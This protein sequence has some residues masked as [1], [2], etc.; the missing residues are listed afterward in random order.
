MKKFEDGKTYRLIN[1]ADS[2][3]RALNVLS[4]SKPAALTNVCLYKYDA[5]DTCQQWIY[6]ETSK[7]KYFVCKANTALALDQ[8]TGSSSTANVKNYNAHVYA[9][10]ATSYIIPKYSYD[11][12]GEVSY[13]QI[14]L[15]NDTTKYLTANENAS[16]TAAGK[17]VNAAGNV[18]WYKQEGVTPKSQDW[19]VEVV[20]EEENPNPS[21][22][23]AALNWKYVFDDK[24]N[25]FGYYGYDPRGVYHLHWGI[26]VIC[27]AGIKLRAPAKATV[28]AVGGSTFQHS[29]NKTVNIDNCAP[30]GTMGY[31]VVLK[32][33]QNDP[34]TNRPMYVRFLHMRDVPLVRYGDTVTAGELLGYVG[35]TGASDTAH[36]H[37]DI[38]TKT[39]AQYY[40]DGFSTSNTINPVNFFPDVSFPN[41]YYEYGMYE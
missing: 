4:D 3:R 39:S 6:K 26:D 27:N 41:R 21:N 5:N 37:L 17:D 22:P 15:A 29:G 12:N 9:P 23:Y 8:F 31:F 33:N 32:M 34:V 1:R 7:G 25:S 36:L 13:V 20:G 16:G 38:N 14:Q 10:S 30:H 28:Y 11:S 40:G 35:N 19:I 18:Y 24:S 2:A